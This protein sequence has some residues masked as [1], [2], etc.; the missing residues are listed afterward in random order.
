MSLS[1]VALT[2][3]LNQLNDG[4]STNSHFLDEQLRQNMQEYPSD[5]EAEEDAFSPF[6]GKR[7][8]TNNLI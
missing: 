5:E 6:S 7:K 4:M 8:R 3:K 1:P 2:N